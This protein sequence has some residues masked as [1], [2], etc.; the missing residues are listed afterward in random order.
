MV[1]VFVFAMESDLEFG[2]VLVEELEFEEW[3]WATT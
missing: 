3:E 2:R 1:M